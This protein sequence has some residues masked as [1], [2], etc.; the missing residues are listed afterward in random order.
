L[1]HY[2]GQGTEMT[3]TPKVRWAAFMHIGMR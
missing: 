1:G 3:R 2:L